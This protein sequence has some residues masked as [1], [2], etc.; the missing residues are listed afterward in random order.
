MPPSML[1]KRY[2]YIIA[3]LIGLLALG[4]SFTVESRN[5]GWEGPIY[6]VPVTDPDG[7]VGIIPFTYI[8]D[9]VARYLRFAAYALLSFAAIGIFH[10][11][12]IVPAKARRR[13][14]QGRLSRANEHQR[15]RERK[16]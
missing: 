8:G 10:R 16:S 1:L 4:V 13:A 2:W 12:V 6:H 3:L 7:N 15:Q 14:A 11:V 5:L 9:G